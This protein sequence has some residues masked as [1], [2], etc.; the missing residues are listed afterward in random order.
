MPKLRMFTWNMQRGSSIASKFMKAGVDKEKAET[1]LRLLNELCATHDVGFITEAGIDL[2][3]A[4]AAPN[5][6][7]VLA[8]QG[9]GFW[10]AATREGT[11][12]KA[13][14]CRNLLF[15]K[16]KSTPQDVNFTSGKA[17]SSR[18]PASG[19]CDNVLLISLHA[20]S[21]G[22][23]RANVEELLEKFDD[24]EHAPPKVK[25]KTPFKFLIIGGD[26]NSSSS[27]YK[28]PNEATQSSG[29]P[30]DGFYLSVMD[31]QSDLNILEE[32]IVYK[33]HQREGWGDGDEEG[34]G[35]YVFH[36]QKKADI[37]LYRVSD[38]APVSILVEYNEVLDMEM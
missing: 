7:S 8:P 21:G 1:R 3:N 19:I 18:Y 16:G 14:G 12:D 9:F 6:T 24:P 27:Q 11:Q 4:I 30:L 5:T 33:T 15:C 25:I 20:T 38:H 23:G 36:S 28:Q 13:K 35:W 10:S 22:G 37:I 34:R 26:L 17:T 31:D 29:D 32:P 2:S